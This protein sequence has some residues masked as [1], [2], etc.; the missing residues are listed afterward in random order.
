MR[1]KKTRSAIAI[2]LAVLMLLTFV[3]SAIGSLSAMAAVSQ[4]QIDELEAQQEELRAERDL[5]QLDID[6][7]EA[8]KADAL[9]IKQALDEQNELNREEIGLI[10]EQ[11]ELYNELVEQKSKELD[12]ALALEEEQLNTYRTHVRMMEENGDYSYFTLLFGSSSLSDLLSNIDMVGEI[13]DADKRLYDQYTE[14]REETELVKADYEATLLELEEKLQELEERKAELEKSIEDATAVIVG[15][16]EDIA[17][18]TAAYEANAAQDAAIAAEVANLAAALAAQEEAARKAAEEAQQEYTGVGSTATGTY[19]WPCPSSTY[20]S[21]LYGMRIHPIFLTERH[22]NGIDV[23]AN[24]GASLVAIDSGTVQ[25]ATYSSSAGNY[26]VIYH[27][28]G[29][30]S[31]YMHMSSMAV[32]AGDTVTKGQVIGYVGSTGWSTGP[33]L[34]FEMTV[35]GATVDPLNYFS[36]YTVSPYA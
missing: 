25:I 28:S 24:E 22:H 9:A 3:I 16:E 7:L 5:M 20:I 12:A 29:T 21:S 10:D 18:Y 2:G 4:S 17:E 8:E 14:A 13:M 35:G 1:N 15:L 23:S 27:S 33:H 32:S 6:A 31:T 34:H 30:T 26:V 19:T 11:I 36:N